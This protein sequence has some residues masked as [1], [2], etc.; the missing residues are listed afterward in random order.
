MDIEKAKEASDLYVR[1]HHTEV[2]AWDFDATYRAATD[3]NAETTVKIP[4]RWLPVLIAKA[5]EEIAGIE[6]R[7]LAL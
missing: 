1:K 6:K 5:Y 7:I 2:M 3:R 4:V